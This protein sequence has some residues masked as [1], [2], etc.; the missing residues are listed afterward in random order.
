MTKPSP[1]RP[2]AVFDIDG[3]ITRWQFLHAINDQLAK[4]GYIDQKTYQAVLDARMTWKKRSHSS[5]YSDYEKT[6]VEIWEKTLP[7]LTTAEFDIVVN[8][9][10]ELYKDQVY[11]YTRDLV[12]ELK[13]Q[14]YIL[15]IISGSPVEVVAKFA[16]Y[17][18]F[19]DYIGTEH[20][21][22]QGK[23]TGEIKLRTY[24]KHKAVEEL[25][26]KH[27]LATKGS[28]GVGDS[29]GD[30]GMLEMIEQPIAFNPDKALYDHAR[31]HGWKIVVERKS[32][33]YE[34]S[35]DGRRFILA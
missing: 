33:V 23:Y 24:D 9:I 15:L 35:N 17:Y 12:R 20:P 28:I 1:T 16:E 14:D 31:K 19:D 8:Q 3:T 2:F 5:S 26:A 30:I 6:L 10:F 32:I 27:G 13:A 7:H 22:E 25:I 34:L 11:T 29:K 4:D 18:G 21:H